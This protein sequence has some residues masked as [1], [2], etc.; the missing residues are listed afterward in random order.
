MAFKVRG[1]QWRIVY[2]MS[3]GGTCDFVLF[4]NGP[5]A[6]VIGVGTSSTDQSF[7]LNARK[8]RAG[9]KTRRRLSRALRT[10]VNW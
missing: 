9:K 10:Y 6:Q 7:G 2:R 8:E 5:S 4:C 1:S 3:Y